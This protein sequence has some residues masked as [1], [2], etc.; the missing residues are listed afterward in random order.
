MAKK[1]M[2]SGS[3]AKGAVV[4]AVLALLWMVFPSGN[5]VTVEGVTGAV[6]MYKSPTCGCCGIYSRYMENDGNLKMTVVNTNDPSSIS[7]KYGVPAQLRSCH[8]TI[9]GGYFVEGHVPIEAINKLL[10]EKPDI[11]GI[12]MPGMPSG[13]PGMPGAKTGDFVIYAVGRDGG[14]SEFMVM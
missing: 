4:V 8:T 11:K 12:A 7:T 14:I 6:T 5:S 2:F 9:I 13:S 3:F 10:K 1:N